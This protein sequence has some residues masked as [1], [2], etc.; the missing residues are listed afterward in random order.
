MGNCSAVSGSSRTE[1][2][3]PCCLATVASWRTLSEETDVADQNATQIDAL[4]SRSGWLKRPPPLDRL[5]ERLP[6]N[7]RDDD[8]K[9]EGRSPNVCP[10]NPAAHR[11]LSDDHRILRIAGNLCHSASRHSRLSERRPTGYGGACAAEQDPCPVAQTRSTAARH[12]R[13]LHGRR[14]GA[15]RAHADRRPPARGRAR[16]NA[17]HGAVVRRHHTARLGRSALQRRNRRTCFPPCL[18]PRLIRLYGGAS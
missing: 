6:S 12:C 17:S 18:W 8:I 7:C 1:M 16:V 13:P 4:L 11:S 15:V 2:S 5:N 9:K 10:R 3:L 14:P